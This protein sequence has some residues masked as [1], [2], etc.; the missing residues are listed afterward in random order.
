MRRKLIPIASFHVGDA[1][2]CVAANS[3]KNPTVRR[4][5]PACL[6]IENAVCLPNTGVGQPVPY[7]ARD[8][9]R[10][11]ESRSEN[12]CTSAKLSEAERIFLVP[13][14]DTENLSRVRVHVLYKR[15]EIPAN[16]AVPALA[17][18]VTYR[19]QERA[20]NPGSTHR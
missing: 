4:T 1:G 8:P 7:T 15:A 12:G 2:E 11:P 17:V 16:K 20:A 10:K 18:S 6:R 13:S 19:K 14:S 9:T 5:R 3:G